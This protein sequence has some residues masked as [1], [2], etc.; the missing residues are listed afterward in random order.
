LCFQHRLAEKIRATFL[1]FAHGTQIALPVDV[2]VR[3]KKA[4]VYEV[5][6]GKKTSDSTVVVQKKVN[7]SE[8]CLVSRREDEEVENSLGWVF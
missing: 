5:K 1:N 3:G 8:M 6:A 7:G 2:E 4:V